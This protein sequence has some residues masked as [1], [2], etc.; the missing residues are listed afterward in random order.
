MRVEDVTSRWACIGLWGPKARDVLRG[1]T[2]GADLDFPYMS[3]R[4]LGSATCRCARCA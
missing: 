4:E 3:L 1:C 2:L